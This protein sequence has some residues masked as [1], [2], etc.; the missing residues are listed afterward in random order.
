MLVIH[1]TCLQG[2]LELRISESHQLGLPGAQRIKSE[3]HDGVY[4][5]DIAT[6]RT[7]TKTHSPGSAAH[8][9]FA[10]YP[11]PARQFPNPS[12]LLLHT[13]GMLVRSTYIVPQ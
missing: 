7:M 5:L 12:S 9:A 1:P 10:R 8:A 2:G 3:C 6:R 4:S 13:L 11:P